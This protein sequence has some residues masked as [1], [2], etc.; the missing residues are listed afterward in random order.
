MAENKRKRPDLTEEDRKKVVSELLANCTHENGEATLARGA[1]D[2]VAKKF[3]INQSTVSRIWKRAKSNWKDNGAYRA[4]PQKKGNCGR[5]PLYDPEEVKAALK[6]IPLSGR[7]TIRKIAAAL[8]IPKTTIHKMK[9]DGVIRAH[10]N[11]IKPI[12]T[13][14]NQ[15]IRVLYAANEVERLPNGRW[16]FRAGEDVVH[17]DEKWFFLTEKNMRT[18][19]GEDEDEPERTTRNKNHII[20]VMFLAAVARPRFDEDGNCTFDGKIGIWPMVEKVRAKRSS[21][22]RKKGTIVTTP[23]NIDSKVYL[24]Y[25]K[26][27]VLPAIRRKWPGAT[28]GARRMTVF[29]QHDNAPV[30]FDES[31]EEWIEASTIDRHRFLFLLKEQAANSPDTNILDLG[32][33]RALQ[34]LQWEQKPASNVDE[35]IANVLAAWEQF[36]PMKINY[37]FLTHQ[38]CLDEIIKSNGDNH[39]K[40]PH[41][42]KESLRRHGALP[43]RLAVSDAAIEQLDHVGLLP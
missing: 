7:R 8:G 6:S 37:N 29:L 19:L 1:Q 12:L 2:A 14:E 22:Y 20:K 38:S 23:I 30:H 18:Y 24:K 41:M 27:K 16:E 31:D 10:T 15:F 36:D 40:I 42:G 9:C 25:V 17:L 5:K 35:L 4:T 26:E 28:R 34:T 11:D 13:P 32:F 43:K 33:F 39:Y 21:K 3:D